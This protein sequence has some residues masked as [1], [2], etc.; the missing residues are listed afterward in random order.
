MQL[1]AQLADR[2]VTIE[3][4][5]EAR[6]WLCTKGYDE[7]MGARPMARVI[8]SEI[9]TQLADELLF[10]RLKHGGTVRVMVVND[11]AGVS[12]LGFVY[13]DGPVLPRPERD[14]LDAG[15]KREAQGKGD[16]KADGKGGAKGG[17]AG[18][19]DDGDVSPEQAAD[20]TIAIMNETM[21]QGKTDEQGAG[22]VKKPAKPKRPQKAD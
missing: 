7:A 18:D 22:D 21:G 9:K 1:E 5:D 17:G 11:E 15:R 13:P 12:K 3:L 8:Q 20:L 16:G 4:T 19:G 2:H 6:K 10:G 14:I